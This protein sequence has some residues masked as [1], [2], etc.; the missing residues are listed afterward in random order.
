MPASASNFASA[1]QSNVS[2]GAQP[3]HSLWTFDPI[4]HM[5]HPYGMPSSFMVGHHT[6]PSTYSENL[7]I[8]RPHFYYPRA[9]APSSNPQQSLTNASLVALKHQMED[10]NHEMVNIMT[11]QIALSE[12]VLMEELPM[13]WKITKF[14]IFDGETNESTVE[15]IT[16]YLTEVSNIANNENLRMKYFPS[17]LTKNAFTWF[18]TLPPCSI[19]TWSQLE[20]AFHEQF[21]M[22]NLRLVLK[23]WPVFDVKCSD[24]SSID[25]LPQV[26]EHELVEMAI[27]GLDCSILKKLDTQYL[28]DM[29]QLA[30]RVQQVERLKAEKAR[31]SRFGKK[32]TVAYVDTNDSDQDF[33][34]EWSTIEESE[35]NVAELKPGPPYTCKVLKPSNGKN[36]EEP[37][38][39]KYASK[40]YTFD[41]TKCHNTSRCV[42][43]RDS[44]QKAFDEGMLKFED[45]SKQPMQVDPLKKA[46]SMYVDI[47]DVNM[48][49]I[50]KIELVV[51]TESPKVDFEMAIEDH[52]CVDAMVTKDQYAK[53]IKCPRCSVVFEKEVAKNVEGFRPQSK[54]KGKRANKKPKSSFDKRGVPY[55][56][57][58]PN[59]HQKKDQVKTFNTPSNSLVE[60]WVFSD[61]KKSNY[62]FPPAKFQRQKVAVLKD[63]MNTDNEVIE[64]EE[65]F[66]E[67]MVVHNP[68]CYYVMNNDCVKDNQ[69]KFDRP[70][71]HMKSHLKPLFTQAKINNIGVNKVLLDGGAAVNLLPQSLLK[72]ISLSKSDLKPHNVALSNYEGRSGSSFGAFEVDLVVGTIKTTTLFLVMPSKTNY[73]C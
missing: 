56:D 73:K 13:G 1:A 58:P 9:N 64:D 29:A 25:A 46:Y 59:G 63:V 15:H 40:T 67:E 27:D 28:R 70:D 2:F 30:D 32:E 4:N 7:N 62:I 20:K 19:F 61:G 66:T 42:I 38:N 48:V 34:F 55:K 3:N 6:N 68:M 18:T 44:V 47:A 33:D 16:R 57:T 10:C 14:T 69:V 39:D 43:F 5:N 24:S 35:I 52:D 26:P 41:V 51:A 36:H 65:D 54:R 21:Y 71:Y 31:T 23:N 72:K 53:K 11:Q 60:K 8:V 17:S 45:K 12:Y 49:E 50:S 37:K 22:S